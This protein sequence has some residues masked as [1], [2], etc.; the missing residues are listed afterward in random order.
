MGKHK[1][2]IKIAFPTTNL[3]MVST[4]VLLIVLIVSNFS[5]LASNPND[6][7]KKAI[8][9][10]NN[11][12]V[13]GGGV[14]FVSVEDDNGLYK[15]TTLYQGQKIPI[16][17]TKD[18]NYVFL[19]QPASLAPQSTTT[20]QPVTI[21]KS[22]KPVVDLYV[23]AQCPYGKQAE[24]MMKPVYDLLKNDADFNLIFIG[25]VTDNKNTA[26]Q[27]CF[28]GQGKTTD[29]AAKACCNVYDI[30]GKTI[31]SCGLHGK[32]EALESE[33]QACILKEH[34]K[35]ALWKY[36]AEFSSSGDVSK[37]INAAGAAADKITNC[38][39]DYG[40]YDVLQGNSNTAEQ[41]NIHGSESIILNSF[42]LSPAG[43]RWSPENLKS[44]ICQA[45]NTAP[46]VCSQTLSG[47]SG[48]TPTS[49]S[50]G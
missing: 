3:W 18:G 14:S 40:W 46:S 39:S 19:S 13:Q 44:L 4:L 16:Y 35:D 32:A 37:S 6:T 31:Y 36:V 33:R 12:A 22:G 20:T 42:K 21:P 50:C 10:I 11:N 8:D 48:G 1:R 41:N 15:V 47:G 17:V 24:T 27:S 7:A 30:N 25:P 43:Y 38:M 2:S 28:D 34:D 29:D 23:W 49:A 5:G 45:F 26:A 9:Y